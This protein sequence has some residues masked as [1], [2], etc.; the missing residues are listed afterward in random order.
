[1]HMPQV[2]SQVSLQLQHVVLCCREMVRMLVEKL[3]LQ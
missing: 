3:A 1:M 2:V